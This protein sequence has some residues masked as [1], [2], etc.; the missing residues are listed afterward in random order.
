M[1]LIPIQD[2]KLLPLLKPV[3]SFA[4]YDSSIFVLGFLN[5]NFFK[6]NYKVRVQKIY[7]FFFLSLCLLWDR[8]PD[9]VLDDK[10]ERN[11]N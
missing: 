5:Y 3:C 10:S 7:R 1:I 11:I 2:C 6:F 4:F 8:K 9:K